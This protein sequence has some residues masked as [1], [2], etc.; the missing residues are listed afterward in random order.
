MLQSVKD[1]INSF[2]IYSPYMH[3]ELRS[4]SWG[5][6]ET[7][8]QIFRE[9]FTFVDQTIAEFEFIPEYEEIINWMTDTKGKGLLL[10]GSCG[11]GK[12]IIINGLIPILMK[13]KDRTVHPIHAQN[14]YFTPLFST[15]NWACPSCLEYLLRT[16]YP[17]IDELGVEG[18]KNDY[19]EKTEGFNLIINNAEVTCKPVF[20]STNL[21]DAQIINRYGERTLDRLG[22]LCRIVTFSGPSLRK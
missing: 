19:G 17:I 13:M 21:N 15:G 10:M 6:K 7:C 4:F 9:I 5:D 18:L 22:H 20:V 16:G 14:F 12:S 11:R 1:A 2:G 8:R 3:R